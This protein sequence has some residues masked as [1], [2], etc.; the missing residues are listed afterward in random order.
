MIDL[1][2][3]VDDLIGLALTSRP[4]LASQQAQV[5]ATLAMLRQERLRPLIPSIL[6]RGSSTPVTG[7]LAAGYYGGGANSSISNGALRSDLDLQVLWQFDNLGFGNRARVHQR[8]AENRV[9]VLNL[10]RVQDRI[11]AE[12]V[13]AYAEADS[14]AHRITL[15]EKEAR[16]ALDSADKNLA[17]LSQTKRIGNLV[18]TIVPPGSH[19]R[20][21]G[22]AQATNDYYGASPTAIA[23]NFGS[24]EHWVNRPNACFTIKP[25]PRPPPPILRTSAEGPALGSP[26]GPS[27]FP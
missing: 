3:S 7:T 25:C 22:V 6:L 19:R 12:V 18:Q 2:Q 11:A 8:E 5:Q 10:F 21:A 24:I 26:D 23:L 16:L 1:H 15:A 4:E 20:R 27:L 17:A 14:A 9:A 13:Q